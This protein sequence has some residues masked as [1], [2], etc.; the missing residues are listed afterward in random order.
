MATDYPANQISFTVTWNEEPYH[1]SVWVIVDYIKIENASTAGNS[2]KRARVTGAT[3]TGNGSA[4]TAAETNRGFWINTSG[5]SGSANVTATLNPD[6]GVQ[7]FNWCAYAL[8]YPPEAKIKPEG[9][10]D[11]Y[12][13]PPFRI[14]YNNSSSTTT[15]ANTFNAGCI[16]AITDATDNPAGIVPPA[17]SLTLASP[18]ITNSQTV[19]A[20]SPITPIIYTTAN[21]SGATVAGLP[22]GVSGA[23]ANNTY[24][25]SGTPTAAATFNYTV[26]TTNSCGYTN[27][28]DSGKIAV[29][30]SWNYANW[31]CGAQTWSGAL[32]VSAGC[33]SVTTLS[34][35]RESASAQFKDAGTTYGYYYN[36]I[37][38]DSMNKDL[39]PDP[40]RVPTNEDYTTL[41]ACAGGK[42]GAVLSAA[43]GLAGYAHAA[44]VY[45]A[46]TRGFLWANDYYDAKNSYRLMYDEE[47][48]VMDYVSALYGVNVRCVK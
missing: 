17:P 11:L 39:C 27:V 12:G 35:D 20:G 8:N 10:Y 34:T 47:S 24:T 15:D 18:A 33:T 43:W 14:T 29:N 21:A 3:A 7:Q 41:I 2:W 25:I 44:V 19:T 13:T 45:E 36:H 30:F 4:A 1:D 5:S 37:C 9:G 16:T 48:Q 32:R 23:W 6:A 22:P 40:W 31:V 26:T 38:I 46:N 42:S 28:T